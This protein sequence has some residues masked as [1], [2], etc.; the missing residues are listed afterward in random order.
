MSVV[1]SDLLNTAGAKTSEQNAKNHFSSEGEYPPTPT[2]VLSHSPPTPV[3]ILSTVFISNAQSPPPP[4]AR[5]FLSRSRRSTAC[6]GEH[7]T[8]TPPPLPA[9]TAHVAPSTRRRRSGPTPHTT[10]LHQ[11]STLREATLLPGRVCLVRGA[12]GTPEK[13]APRRVSGGPR[14]R[15][16]ADI[17]KGGVWWKG[18][19]SPCAG[20]WRGGGATDPVGGGAMAALVWV[21][22][23]RRPRESGRGVRASPPS[24]RRRRKRRPC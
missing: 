7:T 2:A 11:A 14:R 22:A 16:T 10:Q 19:R 5:P 1:E 20:R 17:G 6:Q 24:H 15:T 3:K 23:R 13:T 12:G 4:P 18:V 8:N 21:A 9:A